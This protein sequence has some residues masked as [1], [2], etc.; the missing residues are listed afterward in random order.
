MA[1]SNMII[2]DMGSPNTPAFDANGNPVMKPE[3]TLRGD[4]NAAFVLLA[5]AVA[6]TGDTELA[7]KIC[8]RVGVQP[9]AAP[10]WLDKTHTNGQLIKWAVGAIA[11]Y[12]VY[13]LGKW[14]FFSR[15]EDAEAVA[16]LAVSETNGP[17][18]QVF[19]TP[20]WAPPVPAQ[21][22]S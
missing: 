8:A 5:R 1:R 17:T 6:Q 10:G 19:Q 13:R 14:F 3:I 4:D 15:K 7:N 16:V 9:P 20:A 2:V 18:D 12:G 21:V 22:R 11:L